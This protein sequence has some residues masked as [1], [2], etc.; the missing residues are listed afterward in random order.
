MNKKDRIEAP[1]NDSLQGIEQVSDRSDLS[2]LYHKARNEWEGK[3]ILSD[4][5]REARRVKEIESITI[6]IRRRFIVVGLLIPTPIIG[7]AV[8][9]SL[10]ATYLTPDTFQF[11]VFPAIVSAG[12]WMLISFLSIKKIRAIF[13]EH[14]VRPGPFA[15]VLIALLGLAAQAS[16][17]ATR[18]IQTD[19]LVLNVA[20]VS[21]CTYL[22]SFVLSGL[23]LLIWASQKI[24]G[25]TKMGYIGLLATI[26]I[27][28]IFLVSF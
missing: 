9:L 19:S 5:E 25:Q 6:S 10:A 14:T 12:V 16:F 22:A 3:E 27:G 2:T 24:S 13:Y 4:E 17:L 11:M 26:M 18:P 20:I 8:L 15:I 23:L 7:L 28:L 1:N 21:A